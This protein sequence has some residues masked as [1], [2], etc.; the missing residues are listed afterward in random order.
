MQRNAAFSS[1]TCMVI[2]HSGELMPYTP[3][4]PCAW[5]PRCMM[6]PAMASTFSPISLYVCHTYAPGSP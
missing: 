5:R 6:P 4:R 3:I 2:I 1:T